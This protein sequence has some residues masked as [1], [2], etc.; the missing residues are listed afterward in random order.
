MIGTA[1]ALNPGLR[2][3]DILMVAVL[4]VPISNNPQITIKAPALQPKESNKQEVKFT[5]FEDVEDKLKK[6]Q[7]PE[8]YRRSMSVGSFASIIEKSD[9]NE[10]DDSW[11]QV[12]GDSKSII[13]SP[14]ISKSTN[15]TSG[16]FASP[17]SMP[18]LNI[19]D[20]NSGI[21]T[22][23]RKIKLYDLDSNNA[24]AGVQNDNKRRTITVHSAEVSRICF[25]SFSRL[26]LCI[27]NLSIGLLQ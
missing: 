3:E 15:N 11:D 24:A 16:T 7:R 27:S 6:Y 21:S 10:T 20:K 19:E 18:E 4:A 22:P 23:V 5:F 12:S 14:P 9:S 17:S 8:N 25:K 1:L 13:E 26:L 2:R